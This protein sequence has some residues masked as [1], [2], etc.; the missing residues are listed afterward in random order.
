MSAWAIYTMMG[1]YPDCPADP[2]YSLTTPVFDRVTLHLDSR[3]YPK[4]V[5]TIEKKG[6]GNLI[7]SIEVGGRKYGK[8]R[9]SHDQL[10]N[11]GTI[12]FDTKQ[13]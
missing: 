2:S 7:K 1:F 12:V 10:V 9:I 8:F 4:K 3:Y 6:T 5:L 11:A 13:K